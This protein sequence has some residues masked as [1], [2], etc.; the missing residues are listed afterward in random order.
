MLFKLTSISKNPLSKNSADLAWSY[1]K[2][3]LSS[4]LEKHGQS[5]KLG[6]LI[7]VCLFF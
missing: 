7:Q 2:K 3:N 1:L 4:I 6:V 5:E